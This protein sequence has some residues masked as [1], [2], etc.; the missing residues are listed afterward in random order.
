MITPSPSPPPPAC[1]KVTRFIVAAVT[2]GGRRTECLI[3]VL[4]RL[5]IIHHPSSVVFTAITQSRMDFFFIDLVIIQLAHCTPRA[6]RGPRD[7]SIIRSSPGLIR[8]RF[9][10]P[11]ENN[12]TVFNSTRDALFIYF[13]KGVVTVKHVI[14]QPFICSFKVSRFAPVS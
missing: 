9:A 10:G 3:C 11:R 12:Y 7:C 1:C 13:L 8:L 4:R 14:S 5:L 6:A 2:D